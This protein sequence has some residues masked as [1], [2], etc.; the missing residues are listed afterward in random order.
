VE[1]LGWVTAFAFV[2]MVVGGLGGIL[3]DAI[4]EYL[5]RLRE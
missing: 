4:V 5:R 2:F 1:A 3:L